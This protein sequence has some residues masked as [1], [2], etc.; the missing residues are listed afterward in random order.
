M[1][2]LTKITK[3]RCE[4][5]NNSMQSIRVDWITGVITNEQA[6]DRLW[7]V[8]TNVAQLFQ[9]PLTHTARNRVKELVARC[10]AMINHITMYPNK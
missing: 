2:Y 8:R 6:V 4:E 1:R 9:F 3:E 10:D 7:T 5:C